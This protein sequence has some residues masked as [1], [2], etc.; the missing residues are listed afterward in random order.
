MKTKRIKKKKDKKTY[1]KLSDRPKLTPAELFLQEG[2]LVRVWR[3]HP[4]AK[5]KGWKKD[6]VHEIQKPPKGYINSLAGVFILNKKNEIDFLHFPYMQSL[7]V[8]QKE[9]KKKKK[10]KAK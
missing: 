1:P 8:T 6:S 10:K 4:K 9:Y 3:E 5:K 2:Y 7:R